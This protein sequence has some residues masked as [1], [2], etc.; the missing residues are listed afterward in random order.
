MPAQVLDQLWQDIRYGSRMLLANPAF[1][2]VAVI[3]LALG[4]GANCAIFTWT[5]ALLLRPLPVAHPGE[6]LTVGSTVSVQG[7]TSIITSYPDYVDVRDQNKSFEGL[8][9]FTFLPAGVARTPDELPKLRMGMAVSGNLFGLM[10]VQ[11]DLGRGFAGR[12]AHRLRLLPFA[13]GL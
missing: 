6:V 8:A 5:D 4:I 13:G 1:T 9:A 10:S 7:F 2:I 11:P 3:S 12:I